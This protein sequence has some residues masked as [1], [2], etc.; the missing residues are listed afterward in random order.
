[1]IE[2]KSL[3]TEAIPSALDMAKR[4]YLMKEPEEAESICMDILA[5]DPDHQE[6]LI[7][8]L[9]ALTDK[10]ADSGLQPHFDQANTIVERLNSAYCKSYY[11]GIIFEQRAKYHLK[12]NIPNSRNIAYGWIIKALN[13]FGE[14]L[15]GCDPDNQ[16]AVLR[17]NYC[18]RFINNHPELKPDGG[19]PPEMLL[20]PFDTPH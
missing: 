18:A 7:T 5:I 17:W 11:S 19:D 16:D 14:A 6:A 3:T 20:D 15:T 1:M 9:L 2:L 10:F 4:Y 12:R 8:L 13:A